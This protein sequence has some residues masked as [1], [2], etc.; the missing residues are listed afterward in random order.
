M[1]K[2]FLEPIVLKPENEDLVRKAFSK[3]SL[4]RVK[5]FNSRKRASIKRTTTKKIAIS[6]L[7]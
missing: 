6:E 5:T 4:E 3:E 7:V 2:A 1:T